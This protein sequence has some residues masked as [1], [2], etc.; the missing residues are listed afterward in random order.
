MAGVMKF[1]EFHLSSEVAN[2][3]KMAAGRDI[4]YTVG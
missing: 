4:H 3:N 1:T 2:G